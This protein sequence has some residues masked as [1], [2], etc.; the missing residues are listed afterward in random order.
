MRSLVIG[1]AILCLSSLA[2]T[3]CHAPSPTSIHSAAHLTPTH[4]PL[5]TPASGPLTQGEAVMLI[6]EALAARGVATDTLKITIAGEPRWVTIRYVSAYPSEGRA[7]QPQMVLAALDA[8]TVL[9]RVHPPINGGMRLAAIP[10][11]SRNVGLE[12]IIIDAPSLAAWARGAMSD[13][14]LVSG[15]TGGAMTKE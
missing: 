1:S 4:P 2:I 13:Q 8:A 10:R 7:F 11:R 5:P 14:E 6:E 9:A 12:G 3:A 15:W